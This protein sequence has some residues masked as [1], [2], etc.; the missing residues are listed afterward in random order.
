MGVRQ[1][2]RVEGYRVAGGWLQNIEEFRVR[3]RVSVR[4][5]EGLALCL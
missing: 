1:L 4:V 3:V 5:R 2:G